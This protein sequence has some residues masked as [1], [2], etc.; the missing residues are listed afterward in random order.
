MV[1]ADIRRD[2]ASGPG[3][4]RYT[5][6]GYGDRDSDGRPWAPTGHIEVRPVMSFE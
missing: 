4:H 1:D 2:T 5:G 6:D 3:W